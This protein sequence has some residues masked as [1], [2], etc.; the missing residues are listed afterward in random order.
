MFDALNRKN[1]NEGVTPDGKDMEVCALI[2]RPIVHQFDQ[3]TS[4]KLNMVSLQILKSSLSWLDG[5]ETNF[6]KGSITADE[7]LTTNTAEGLRVTLHATI[8]MCHYLHD[9]FQFKYL[10]TG[11]LNQ[12]SLEVGT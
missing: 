2:C 6:R 3:S 10:L 4:L 5:W 7:F 8:D 9:Q 11:K 1:P 12:D